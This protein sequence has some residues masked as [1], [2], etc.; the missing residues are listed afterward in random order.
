MTEK[1]N[2]TQERFSNK[3]NI[4]IREDLEYSAQK[5]FTYA[6]IATGKVAMF[7]IGLAA[8]YF[9]YQ[10]GILQKVTGLVR[11]DKRGQTYW[12]FKEIRSKSQSNNNLEIRPNNEVVTTTDL[13]KTVQDLNDY[14]PDF[15]GALNNFYDEKLKDTIE[16]KSAEYKKLL[17]ENFAYGQN[18]QK[19]LIAI[20]LAQIP[21]KSKPNMLN[22]PTNSQLFQYSQQNY[23]CDKCQQDFQKTTAYSPTDKLEEL[24]Q[25]PTYCPNCAKATSLVP[26]ANGKKKPKSKKNT[27]AYYQCLSA[28]CQQGISPKK[29]SQVASECKHNSLTILAQRTNEIQKLNEAYRQIGESLTKKKNGHEQQQL[30][31]LAQEI[32]SI[33]NNLQ[34][35]LKA[36]V[37]PGIKPSHLRKSKSLSDIP[38]A[39]PL[40]NTPLQKSKSQ[41]DIPVSQQPTPSQQISQLQEQV[42]FHAQTSQNYLQSLQVAQAKIIDLEELPAQI[43]Q[44]E[45]QILQLRLDKI[46]EFADYLEK[47][48]DLETELELNI[49]EGISEIK[50]LEN[51]LLTINKKKLELAHKLSQV[52]AGKEP[53]ENRQIKELQNQVH[54]YQKLYQSRVEKDLAKENILQSITRER[55]NYQATQ[56]LL[57]QKITDLETSL[58]NLAKQKIKG[59]KAAEKLLTKDKTNYQQQQEKSTARIN[60]LNQEITQQAQER[61]ALQSEQ[62]QQLKVKA[63]QINELTQQLT[64][65]KQALTTSQEQRKQEQQKFDQQLTETNSQ[66]HQLQVSQTEQAQQFNEQLRKINLLLEKK[67]QTLSEKSQELLSKNQTYQDLLT[68]QENS[69]KTIQQLEQEKHTEKSQL[70]RK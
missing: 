8:G 35:E 66:L 43:K 24:A 68:K 30:N 64:I 42:K 31:E 41:L 34:Q 19:A 5:L 52:Q 38:V 14:L 60:Y 61:Q 51:K 37:K 47:K 4:L 9:L 26:V 20:A 15:K 22:L 70:Y 6:T 50:R 53:A 2:E 54:H 12:K 56:P 65:A 58:L 69:A 29:I 59:K 45:Q 39:P 21:R 40:P 16:N 1:L 27:V 63:T 46:K 17:Q 57:E 28:C 23:T 25:H 49:N 55:N 3:R 10:S 67:E 48:Q 11:T 7:A 18:T 62:E 32:H 13:A 33:Q 44:L 36:K